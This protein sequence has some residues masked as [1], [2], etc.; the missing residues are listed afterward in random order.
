MS[1]QRTTAQ[2][3]WFDDF[4][5]GAIGTGWWENATYSLDQSGGNLNVSVNK[6]AMWSS[7]GV[8]FPSK[9]ITTLPWISL[10][11]KTSTPFVLS[12]YVSNATK[13]MN[14]NIPV[15]ASE[16]F[17]EINYDFS[18]ADADLLADVTMILIAVNGE[19]L[20]WYGD[21]Q[22]DQIFLGTVATKKA[23]IGGVPDLTYYQGTTGHKVLLRGVSNVASYNLVGTSS[24]LEN[25][26][27]TPDVANG[28][29]WMN[30]NVKAGVYGTVPASIIATG[31]STYADNVTYFQLTIERNNTPSFDPIADFEG[32]KQIE[33]KINIS[34]INDGNLAADQTVTIS[35]SSSNTSV[36]PNSFV[37]EKD[38]KSPYAILK[39]TPTNS[40][41]ATITITA[42][43]GQASNNIYT[44]TVDVNVI[45]SWNNAPTLNSIV[46]TEVL[47]NASEQVIEL[48]GIDDGDV[49]S[50]TL[51]ITAV[52]SNPAVIP[53][54]TIVYT[55]GSSGQLKFTPV[56][57][58]NGFATITVTIT[59]N[60][61][62]SGNNGNQSIEK[63]FEIESYAPPLN[64]YVIPFNGATPNAFDAAQTGM[65]DY[66]HVEGLGV[67]QTPTYEMDGGDKVLKLACNGKFTWTGS[68]Y[69]MPDMDLTDY[70]LISVW[71][72][73]DQNIKF[74]L[75]FW[76]D[77]IRNNED[78]HI[79]YDLVA[80][81]WTKLEFDFSDPTGML[82]SRGNPV[83]AKRLIRVLFNYHP[84]FGWPFT[85]WTGNVWMKDIRIGNETS[86]DPTYYC[87]A[88]PIGQQTLYKESTTKIIELS[89]L[90]RGKD[91]NCV[92]SVS[93]KGILQNLQVTTPVNG[94]AVISYTPS[95]AGN[96][97][98]SVLVTGLAINGNL[99]VSKTMEIPVSVVDP[100]VSVPTVLNVNQSNTFQTYRG[101]G[102]MYPGSRMLDLYTIDGFG[103]TAMRIGMLDDNQ[104]EPVNDNDD[105]NVLDRS[106]LNYDAFDWQSIK[107][108]KKNGVESFLITLWS[109]PAWMKKNLSTNYQ[110]PSAIGWESTT[111]K[112]L[113]EMYDEYAELAVTI[114]TVFKEETGFEL[115]GIGLQNEPAFCEPYG[116]AILDPVHFAE[117]IAKVGTRF[118]ALGIN[119]KLYAAEQVGATMGEGPIYMNQNYLDAMNNNATA[120]SYSDVFA[121]HGYSSDGITPGEDPGSTGWANT[122]TAINANGKTRELWMTETE[123][124]FTNWMDAFKNAADI[125][126][127]FESGNVALWTEWSW[128]SH[129]INQGKPTQKYWSQ[130]MFKYIKPG[131]VRMQSTSGNNDILMTTWKN[132]ANHGNGYTIMLMNKGLTPISMKITDVSLPEKFSM[133]AVSEY[134]A[135]KFV[136]IYSRGENILIGPNA[137]VTLASGLKP[138]PTIDDIASRKVLFDAST[139]TVNLTGIT[140][141][142]TSN[143]NPIQ[144][145]H[146]L[147]NSQV[148]ENVNITYSSPGNTATLTFDPLQIGIV[149]VTISVT[150]D[151]ETTTKKFD[152]E[153]TDYAAP[154]INP[155]TGIYTYVENSGMQTIVLNGI[156]DGDDG[157]QDLTVTAEVISSTPANVIANLDVTYTSP[158]ATG[159]LTFDPNIPG[160]CTVRVTVEDNGASNNTYFTEFDI[161]VTPGVG[162]DEIHK[163]LISVF[164]NPSHDFVKINTGELSF[165]EYKI[166]RIDGSLL[167][168]GKVSSNNIELNISDLM[169]GVYY[170]QL[171]GDTN[172][173][174]CIMKQ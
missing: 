61:G 105:P 80:N 33:R 129:C 145:S 92:A 146:S 11:V 28:T 108:L 133:F 57:G 109:P 73:A 1:Y 165:D 49:A 154:T 84:T 106:K 4:N 74:H 81:T 150:A 95:S 151:G 115:T 26:S 130:S 12:L 143:V 34:G 123:P 51:N 91:Q 162:I 82:N 112:V 161:T 126:T 76:D 139:V 83:N 78:H 98:I 136:K 163:N 2:T 107:E 147:S 17:Q 164:P 94:N 70:P 3:S 113:T 27:F 124:G 152:V 156:T 39:F 166:I 85:N 110:Q 167:K 25:V 171:Q 169:S 41:N 99:P 114:A 157:S 6:A 35:A 159:S 135:A 7:F 64:G 5:S 102:S 42:N 23:N 170:I 96:D 9:N 48:T 160:E 40:G 88:N 93:G 54:P 127:A 168:S 144:I 72:K 89:G 134:N 104:I 69:Y 141:G 43:D 79:Q 44:Q 174:I 100:A 15:M 18:S 153:V 65:R 71:V 103:A 137:I 8:S 116:S 132:D 45:D 16:N 172:A 75:Y 50:Q 66:W 97:T 90:S 30:F 58:Q 155:L 118:A 46:D 38:P 24:Y 131:A 53:N 120:K 52:S 128:N 55:G 111:N 119:T 173:S 101:F 68:W 158:Q 86:I 122:F 87:T 121:V 22:L 31:N 67:A 14:V 59:D 13:N 63:Q 19:A 140:D 149:E 20:S 36:I 77:S 138:Q 125:L 60:G 62:A 29:T 47:N 142:N 56:N 37:V 117:M 32:A 21:F 148:I 10:R